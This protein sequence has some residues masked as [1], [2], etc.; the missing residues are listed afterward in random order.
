MILIIFVGKPFFSDFEHH[1]LIAL[2]FD[3]NLVIRL[4]MIATEGIGTGSP[5]A[6]HLLEL[7]RQCRNSTYAPPAGPFLISL[8]ACQRTKGKH[9]KKNKCA[10]HSP[11]E[12]T[13]SKWGVPIF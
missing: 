11:M 9:H 12:D 1:D 10:Q 4:L 5:V 7:H 2:I 13:I 8:N 6:D 3:L